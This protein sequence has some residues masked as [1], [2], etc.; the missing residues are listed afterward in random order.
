MR[1]W[2]SGEK[3]MDRPVMTLLLSAASWGVRWNRMRE[4]VFVELFILMQ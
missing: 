2:K 3:L 4:D 1:S